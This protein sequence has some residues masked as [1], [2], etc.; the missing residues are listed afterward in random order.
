LGGEL[1]K[2]E[3]PCEGVQERVYEVLEKNQFRGIREE[4]LS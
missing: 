3:D 1:E 4:M 2:I